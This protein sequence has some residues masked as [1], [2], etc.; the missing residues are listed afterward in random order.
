[1]TKIVLT[2]VL[3]MA[4]LSA[5]AAK[6]PDQKKATEYCK[7]KANRL[8]IDGKGETRKACIERLLSL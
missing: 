1:M 4:S 8:V 6:R 5:Q 7:V 2:A 3:I